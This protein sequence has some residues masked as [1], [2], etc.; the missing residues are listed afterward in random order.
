MPSS[1]R[2]LGPSGGVGGGTRGSSSSFYWE[3]LSPIA[4]GVERRDEVGMERV[5]EKEEERNGREE[6]ED[7]G[8]ES[9]W[10]ELRERSGSAVPFGRVGSGRMSKGAAA[11]AKLI[12]R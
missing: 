10:R 2:G 8:E 5:E 3:D 4:E 6:E 11:A 1:P 7:E 12:R 9:K